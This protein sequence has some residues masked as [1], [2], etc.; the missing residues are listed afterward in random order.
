MFKGL[1]KVKVFLPIRLIHH[2]KEIITH[3]VQ[4]NI[5]DCRQKFPCSKDFLLCE[6]RIQWAIHLGHRHHW[7]IVLFKFLSWRFCER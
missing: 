7:I 5:S 2:G 6:V 1:G 4:I 3:K